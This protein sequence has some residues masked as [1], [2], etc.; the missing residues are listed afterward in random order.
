MTRKR[1]GAYHP[2]RACECS[3]R[4]HYE[5]KHTV[6]R[7]VPIM[8]KS[9]D[10]II[11]EMGRISEDTE[12]NRETILEVMKIKRLER[13]ADALEGIESKLKRR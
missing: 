4:R 6:K 2:P 10:E 11:E 12:Y 3:S 13:I 8:V 9:T 1:T 7:R 5:K